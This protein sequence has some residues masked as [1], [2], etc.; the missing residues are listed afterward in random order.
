MVPLVGG[1]WP[2]TPSTRQWWAGELLHDL[3]HRGPDRLLR[4][5]AGWAA[6]GAGKPVGEA[7]EATLGYFESRK[8]L[9]DYP[10][11]RAAGWP[12]GTGAIE[13][14]NKLVGEERL[15]GPGMHWGEEHVNPMLA[16]RNAQC[17]NRWDEAWARVQLSDK[18]AGHTAVGMIP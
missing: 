2:E 14:A 10:K 3:K 9:L 4:S 12:I 1:R 7:A 11:L 5:L 13:S 15:K 18:E 16:L 8:D 17:S 6:T